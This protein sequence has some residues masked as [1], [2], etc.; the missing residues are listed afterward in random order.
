MNG[1]LLLEFDFYGDTQVSRTLEGF[2]DR[3]DDAS[4]AFDAMGDRLAAAE[5]QQFASEGGYGSGGWAPLSPEY[6]SWKA[7][8]FPGKPILERT[9]DLREDLTSRPFSIDVVE[10]NMAVFG[11]AVEYARYHQNGTSK[12]PQ[13]RPLELPDSERRAW[14]KVMQRWIVSGKTQ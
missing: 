14:V 1:G 3:I 2:T 13:R 10:T 7:R 8:R 6:A 9:G 12:M 5:E 4:E 11:S